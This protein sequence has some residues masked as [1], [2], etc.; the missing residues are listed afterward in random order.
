M[1]DT[2]K[3]ERIR[4]RTECTGLDEKTTKKLEI[5]VTAEKK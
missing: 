5:I 3:K 1:T 4:K 2:L